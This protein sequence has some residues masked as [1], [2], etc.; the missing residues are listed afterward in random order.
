MATATARTA[1]F[2]GAASTFATVASPG[3]A[4][5]T[6]FN[7]IDTALT[8]AGW[9]NIFSGTNTK[10]YSSNGEAGTETLFLVMTTGAM[11]TASGVD[12]SGGSYLSAGCCQFA[13]ASGNYYNSFGYPHLQTADGLA[14]TVLELE[15]S[16][17][18][19]YAI[20]AD[21]DGLAVT[22]LPTTSHAN[23]AYF[24]HTG[25]LKRATGIRATNLVTS[26]TIS[27][28][29]GSNVAVNVTSNP[30]AAGYQVG[31]IVTVLAQN[32]ISGHLA[33]TFSTRIMTMTSS[34]VTLELVPTLGAN[35]A[36]GALIGEDPQP[37]FGTPRNGAAVFPNVYA[38]SSGS[39][40]CA[41]FGMSGLN[42]Q[43][44]LWT[45]QQGS[46]LGN[47]IANNTFVFEPGSF[48]LNGAS[49]DA[50]VRPDARSGSY[51]LDTACIWDSSSTPVGYRGKIGGRLFQ[52]AT[53]AG[54]LPGTLAVTFGK[55]HTVTGEEWVQWGSTTQAA[56]FWMGPFPVVNATTKQIVNAASDSLS[57]AAVECI[58]LEQNVS[59]DG[60]ESTAT[61][62]TA[63]WLIDANIDFQTS[64]LQATMLDQG[65]S[66]SSD[67]VQPVLI[68]QPYPLDYT[69]APTSQETPNFNRGFN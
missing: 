11:G 5:S 16:L 36:S 64:D 41:P 4:L 2:G 39:A 51:L 29:G 48:S 43:A 20:V 38:P 45:S 34:S 9:T 50:T 37:I 8:T 56:S 13:D 66:T 25:V 12:V 10:S 31:D 62:Q 52:D 33:D 18:W 53:A 60:Y 3:A 57:G 65:G 61:L 7:A 26:G 6:L 40:K 47:V 15:A 19:D 69:Y 28:A 32:G 1:K 63:A 27:S 30:I 22:A 68:D 14:N 23:Q 58:T 21:K 35:I 59:S 54:S 55:R 67:D 42:S 46:A 44:N 24:I 49:G 17:T